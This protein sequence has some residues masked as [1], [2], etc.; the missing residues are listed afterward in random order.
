MY[1]RIHIE[2]ITILIIIAR[3]SV[4][5]GFDTKF[6]KPNSF[7]RNPMSIRKARLNPIENKKVSNLLNMSNLNIFRIKKPGIKVRKI[8]PEICRAKGTSKI[9]VTSTITCNANTYAKTL[10]VF[11]VI[12]PI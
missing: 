11:K 3:V 5:R 2:I 7:I 1:I 8:K 4:D 9:K 6:N 10:E 12:L